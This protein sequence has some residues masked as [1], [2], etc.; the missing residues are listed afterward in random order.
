MAVKKIDSKGRLTLGKRHAN[1]TVIVDDS[2][3]GQLVVIP[4]SALPDHE[5]WLYRNSKALAMVAAGLEDA[6]AGRL[7][8]GPNLK[9]KWIDILAD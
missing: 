9:A 7:V 2:D 3:E 8:R 4:L 5:V 6:Q 1:Q